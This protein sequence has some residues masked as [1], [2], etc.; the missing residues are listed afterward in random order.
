MFDPE[1]GVGRRNSTLSQFLQA[2]EENRQVLFPGGGKALRFTQIQICS[3][4]C[5]CKICQKLK[6]PFFGSVPFR[7][8]ETQ[9]ILLRGLVEFPQGFICLSLRFF[10]AHGKK[11]FASLG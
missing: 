1:A 10:P 7:S 3:A 4:V 5:A 11:L 6:W 8:V 9:R 2:G